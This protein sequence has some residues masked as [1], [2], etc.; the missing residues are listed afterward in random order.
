MKEYII[1]TEISDDELVADKPATSYGELVRCKDCEHRP[2]QIGEGTQGFNLEFPDL[3]CPCQCD[4]GWYNWMPDD[5]WYC[6]NAKKKKEN[7]NDSE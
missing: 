1:A 6:G 5:N 3:G 2:K 7:R 4:D